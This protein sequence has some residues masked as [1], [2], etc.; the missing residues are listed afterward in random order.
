[1]S[2]DPIPGS[3]EQPRTLQETLDVVQFACI[4]QF[5]EVFRLLREV[6]PLRKCISLM[7]DDVRGNSVELGDEGCEIDI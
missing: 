6:L 2:V 3:Q 7:R 4:I 1:M 5:P